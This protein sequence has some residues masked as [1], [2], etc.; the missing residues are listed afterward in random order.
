MGRIA[1]RGAHTI[2]RTVAGELESQTGVG[3]A[4]VHR[5]LGDSFLVAEGYRMEG[6]GLQVAAGEDWTDIPKAECMKEDM[7]S[8]EG[9]AAAVVDMLE[10]LEALEERAEGGRHTVREPGTDTA[11]CGLEGLND[12]EGQ[13][14]AGEDRS[15]A[16]GEEASTGSIRGSCP[17]VEGEH[18]HSAEVGKK[19][20]AAG[21][22]GTEEHG[23]GSAA[24]RSG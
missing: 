13:E 3:M 9:N 23:A 4:G 17:G 6:T 21:G 12:Q 8:Q 2:E 1:G 11:Q 18:S 7:Q 14:V 5:T 16:A 22:R 10:V 20:R 19:D 24:G 15:P